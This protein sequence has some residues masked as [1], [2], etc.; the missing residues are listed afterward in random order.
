[1]PDGGEVAEQARAIAD[2]VLFPAALEVDRS[3]RIPAGHFARLAAAGLY[4]AA[5][6]TEVGGLDLGLPEFCAVLEALASGCLATTFV[7]LQHHAVVRALA[8]APAP[9][10]EEWLGPLC[11][12]ERTAGFAL[13]GAVAGPVRLRAEPDGAGWRLSGTAPWVTGWG[14]VDVLNV[15]ARGPSDTVVSVLLDAAERPSLAARRQRLVAVDAS[16][17]V[18]LQFTE[19]PVAGAQLVSTGPYQPVLS[20]AVHRVNAS[21]ALG[22]LDR[23]CRLLGPSTLDGQLTSCRAALDAALDDDTGD[24]M[25]AARASTA[26]LAVRAAAATVVHTGSR[27][28]LPDQHPQRLAREATFLLVFATRPTIRTAL[29]ANLTD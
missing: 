20:T 4:G 12:G 9:L 6:P 25:S 27:A 7:W 10:R 13:T 24:R 5:A 11:R 17:T 18:E 21:L 15:V 2:E 3:G 1:V 29:L 23:C 14:Y 22:L 26:A 8:G 16:D 19:L 28:L